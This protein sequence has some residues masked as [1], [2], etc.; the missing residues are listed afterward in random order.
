MGSVDVGIGHDEDFMVA[1]LFVVEVV[2]DAAAEG[3][4]DVAD[5]LAAEYLF[6][7]GLF[8]V[9]YLAAQRQDRLEFAVAPLFGAAPRGISLNDV[10]FAVGGVAV[11][12]V[13][14]LPGKGEAAHY[15]LAAHELLGFFRRLAGL[16]RAEGALDDWLQD[17]GAFVEGVFEPFVDDGVDDALDVVV[18]ELGLGLPLELRLHHFDGDDGGESLFEVV[19]GEVV[20]LLFQYFELARLVVYRARHRGTEAGDVG[21]SLD[22]VDEV[23]ESVEPFQVG[24]VVLDGD[25]HLRLVLFAADDH[26]ALEEHLFAFVEVFDEGGDAAGVVVALFLGLLGAQVLKVDGDVRVEEGEFAQ[27]LFED[28]GLEFR[29]G[30]YLFVRH[31]LHARAAQFRIADGLQ[32]RHGDA[33]LITLVVFFA[34]APDRQFEPD[35]E[36][37]DDGD[38]DAVESAGDLV[39]ALVELSARVEHREDDFGRRLARLVHLG[40]DA[41]SVVDDGDAAVDIYRHVDRVAEARERFVYRVVYHFVDEVVK[42]ALALVAD[43][44]AGAFAYRLEPLK[45]VDVLCRIVRGVGSVLLRVCWDVHI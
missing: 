34:V 24:V 12:A 14:Q 32:P 41:A 38:A 22:G 13:R 27:T 31:E 19:A 30:E 10:Y 29:R 9:E 40:G 23:D 25:V 26:G 17:L 33:A 44:H 36:G 45:N 28:V 37:V 18:A 4:D 5:R 20:V 2:A 8:D 6:E 43:V 3:E 16:A 11:R 39:G 7:A 21:A 15:R 1:Q 35:G 42:S